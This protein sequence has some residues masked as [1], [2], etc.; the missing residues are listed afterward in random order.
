VFARAEVPEVFIN[1]TG[2][3]HPAAAEVAAEY[4]ARVPGP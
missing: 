1:G 3:T 4:Q 2:K